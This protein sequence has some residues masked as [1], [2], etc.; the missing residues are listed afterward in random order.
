MPGLG[1]GPDPAGRDRHR[2][3]PRLHEGAPVRRRG[4]P[5]ARRRSR[6]RR[7]CGRTSPVRIAGVNVGEVTASTRRATPR[8]SPSPSTRRASR[9]T[10]TPRSR[11]GPG[12]SSRATSSSTCS[13]GS[14]SAPELD[15]D[16][17][18]AITQTST[19]VQLDEVLTS[20]QSDSREDLQALLEGYGTALT[21]RAHRRG[22]RR[23]RTRDVQGE[24]AAQSINDSFAYGGDA[25]RTTAIV[26]EALPGH[27]AA[28]PLEAD[29]G[30]ARRLR[31]APE[32]ARVL[33]PGPDHE[34]QHHHGRARRRVSSNL[35]A[36]IRELAPTLEEA[37]PSLLQPDRR[38]ALRS[39]VGPSAGAQPARAAGNDR[40]RGPVAGS[41]RRCCCATRSS[42][43]SPACSAS[44]RRRW[45]RRRARQRSCCPELTLTQPLRHR[46][47]R[48]DGRHRDQRST[49]TTRAIP[50]PSGRSSSTAR[51]TSPGP[52]GASTAT[53]TICARWPAAVTSWSWLRTPAA[54]SS[55]RRVTATAQDT[56]AGRP[57]AASREPLRTFRMDDVLPLQPGARTSTVP[58]ATPGPP[59][60][61]WPR[62]ARDPRAPDRLRRDRRAHRLRAGGDRCTSS[63]SSRRRIRPG[64][65]SWA[66]TPSS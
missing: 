50:R 12:S 31:H 13:P 19:A 21:V 62:E 9:S 4:L 47:A 48:P 57:A 23:R 11:S 42:A 66:T 40:G 32:R 15:D 63:P 2:Q 45:L 14:P 36:S 27:R 56:A 30:A 20:L 34:L 6:T 61:R 26:N 7:P 22:G 10:R 49:P 24:T 18:I 41:G 53:A 16:G 33:A 58:P 55:T 37:R 54:V 8:R 35:S 1:P 64:S 17:E 5:A 43:A 28:R 38:A 52:P 39:C 65:R 59:D 29:R 3:R 60:L 25:G 51:S 44:R 46:R